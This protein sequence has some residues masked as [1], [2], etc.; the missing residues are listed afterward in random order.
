[1]TVKT[2]DEMKEKSISRVANNEYMFVW[3][4]QIIPFVW[5]CLWSFHW[6]QRLRMKSMRAARR[7]CKCWFF[8]CVPMI[9]PLFLHISLRFFSTRAVCMFFFFFFEILSRIF[10]VFKSFEC[11][12]NATVAVVDTHT[13]TVCY[14]MVPHTASSVNLLH[15][16][17]FRY[18]FFSS[19][20][21]Q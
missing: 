13:H 8:M 2:W 17:I 7:W 18:N 19:I 4:L 1:M 5:C 20:T 16:N 9:L 11:F 15:W 21:I 3:K 12:W 14:G 10:V 6:I